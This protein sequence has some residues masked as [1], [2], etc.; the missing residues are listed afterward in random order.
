MNLEL[1]LSF[2]KTLMSGVGIDL[3]SR[4]DDIKNLAAKEFLKE[5]RIFQ[6]N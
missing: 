1:L 3:I 6:K 2:I 5:K 4:P